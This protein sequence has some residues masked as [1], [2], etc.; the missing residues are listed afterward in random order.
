MCLEL[1][2]PMHDRREAA[3][4][5]IGPLLSVIRRHT[6]SFTTLHNCLLLHVGVDHIA[7]DNCDSPNSTAQSIF[8]YQR[9]HDTLVK[10]GHPMVFG[11]WNV[12]SGKPWSWAPSLGHYWRTGPDLGTKWEGRI[13]AKEGVKSSVNPMSIMY[14]YDLQQSIPSLDSISG[15]G[16]FALLD[17]LALGLPPNVP[18][19]G[20]PGLTLV[21]ASTHMAI[22]CIMASPL[23]INYNIFAPDRGTVDPEVVKIVMHEEAIAIDQVCE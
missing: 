12:G 3:S 8:E 15:P 14:N 1:F 17:N 2:K 23:I 11:I 13:V 16:S 22:W 7:V 18:H 21:E 4:D 19:K 10:V 20:D 5:I 6:H 9:I